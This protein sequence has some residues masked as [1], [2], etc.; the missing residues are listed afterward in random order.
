MA[1]READLLL[2]LKATD[3]DPNDWPE[4]RITKV[5]V[6]SCK[7][8]RNVS[9]LSAHQHNPVKVLGRLEAIDDHLIHL[10]TV[11]YF[12]L[13]INAISDRMLT[14]QDQRYQDKTIEIDHVSTYAFAQYD[15]GSCGFWAAGRAGW[16]EIQSPSSS[17]KTTYGKM[18][19]AA[20]IFYML[21]DKLKRAHNPHP[22]MNS[23]AVLKY[24][25]G[26]FQDVS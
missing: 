2:P 13:S 7:T 23:K 25:E 3:T 8:G 22:K 9:L 17:Y 12:G 1:A 26:V 6:I 5:K 10:G 20:S 21:A 24:A 4:F 15:D 16:F 14:V 18:N 11:L 19:E